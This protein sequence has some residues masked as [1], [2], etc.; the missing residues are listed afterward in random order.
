M[1]NIPNHKYVDN[2]VYLVRRSL[3]SVRERQSDSHREDQQ[4]RLSSSSRTDCWDT[5]RDKSHSVYDRGN[6][7]NRLNGELTLTWTC[8]SGSKPQ[9]CSRSNTGGTLRATCPVRRTGSNRRSSWHV[10]RRT[11][12]C[13]CTAAPNVDPGR[14]R[15]GRKHPWNPINHTRSVQSWNGRQRRFLTTLDEEKNNLAYYNRKFRFNFDYF[16]FIFFFF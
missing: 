16:I 1:V 4:N 3:G 11:S 9:C 10:L 7:W 12:S 2:C 13:G 5:C 14:P 8:D 6:E 15:T